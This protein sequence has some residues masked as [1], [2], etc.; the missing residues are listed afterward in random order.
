MLTLSICVACVWWIGLQ[1]RTKNKEAVAKKASLEQN[2][3]QYEGGLAAL[4]PG[5]GGVINISQSM[6]KLLEDKR[7][8]QTVTDKMQVVSDRL[9][10]DDASGSGKGGDGAGFKPQGA[11]DPARL[12]A[13]FQ[14]NK[15]NVGAGSNRE[16]ASLNA[17][18]KS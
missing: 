3:Q 7:R 9:T 8:L 14:A 5:E 12:A 17:R 16:L 13:S 11:R 10:T 18:L 2:L 6:A 1:L 4:N 15:A